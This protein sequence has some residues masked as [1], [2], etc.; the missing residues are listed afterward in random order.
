MN[1]RDA[2]DKIQNKVK[3]RHILSP[4]TYKWCEL[5][6]FINYIINLFFW[7]TSLDLGI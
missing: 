6:C 3:N 4:N 7:V 2:V 5:L 1:K